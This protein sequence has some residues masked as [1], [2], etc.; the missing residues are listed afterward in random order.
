MQKVLHQAVSHNFSLVG[1]VS[2]CIVQFFVI[3]VKC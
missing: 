3:N 2:D 1:Y